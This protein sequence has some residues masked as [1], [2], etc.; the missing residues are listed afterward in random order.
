LPEATTAIEHTIT[1]K[2]NPLQNNP[3]FFLLYQER[4]EEERKDVFD[5]N[6]G[7]GG[8]RVYMESYI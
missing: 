7:S 6:V 3:I 8:G 1:N 2:E 5:V 4:R